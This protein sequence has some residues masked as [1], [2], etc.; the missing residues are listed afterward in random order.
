MRMQLAAAA[1]AAVFAGTASAEPIQL[2]YAFPGAPQALI[3]TQAM[4]PWA[5]QVTRSPRA[6][7]RSSC[8]PA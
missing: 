6:R 8:S 3:Y 5:E 7:S 4:V 1:M 2:K